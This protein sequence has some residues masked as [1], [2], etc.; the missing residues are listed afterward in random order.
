[1]KRRKTQSDDGFNPVLKP[2]SNNQAKLESFISKKHPKSICVVN[3]KG[4]VGKT[5][6]T[7]LLGY[8]ISQLHEQVKRGKERLKKK[9]KILLLDIKKEKGTEYQEEVK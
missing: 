4:G 6:I 9:R 2:G 3:Y 1:M 5:T 7:C 8:Y